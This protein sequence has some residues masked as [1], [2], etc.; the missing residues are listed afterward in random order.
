MAA[1]GGEGL[2]CESDALMWPSEKGGEL[3]D[4]GERVVEQA[5]LQKQ[6]DSKSVKHFVTGYKKFQP[7]A[8]PV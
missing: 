8:A 1:D 7:A 3:E 5:E 6:Q 4:E 2:A